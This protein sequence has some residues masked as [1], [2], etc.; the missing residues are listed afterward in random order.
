MALAT[1]VVIAGV[2]LT[3]W[4]LLD[5]LDPPPPLPE[6]PPDLGG[7]PV[8]EH[9]LRVAGDD[10]TATSAAVSREA[11][12]DEAAHAV[13]V[14]GDDYP[15]ALAGAALAG[16]RGGPVLL[17]SGDGLPPAVRAELAW[18]RPR[19]VT[20]LGGPQAVPAAVAEELESELGL[21]GVQRL[22]G[23]TRFETAARAARAATGGDGDR[24]YVVAADGWPD[25][26][27]VSALAAHQ[28]AP[29]LLVTR[30]GLPEPT[31]E[32]ISDLG[33]R[34]VT[35]VGG[36][37]AVSEQVAGRLGE[38]GAE[39]SRVAGANRYATSR[40]VA[41]L[42]AEAGLDAARPWLVTGGDWPDALV[43]G[44]AAAWV[45][46]PL[47]L[48]DGADLDRSPA[49]Q[50]WLLSSPRPRHTTVVGGQAV[51]GTSVVDDV[52]VLSSLTPGEGTRV[53]A[54][55]DIACDPRTRVRATS[56]EC[57]SAE[58]AELA[59]QADEVLVLGDLQSGRAT[60]S[61]LAAAY[62]RT[63]GA[64]TERTHP[65]I[66]RHEYVGG[67]PSDYFAYFGERA[68]PAGR[69]YYAR[70]IGGWQVLS[71][72]SNCRGLHDECDPGSAQMEWLRQ[73]LEGSTATCR[74]ALMHHARFSDGSTHG[75]HAELEA[76]FQ[77]L[78]DGGVDV[79]LAAHA[80]SYQRFRRADAAGNADPEGGVR[81]FVVGTGGTNL[82]P[83]DRRH[84]LSAARTDEHFGVLELTLHDA[85]YTWEFRAAN[86]HGVD[87][88]GHF[89][90]AGFGGCD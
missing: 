5:R 39:V 1:A 63:W 48:V 45:G 3:G 21:D 68:G 75:S 9:V 70:E 11:F 2:S 47:V 43:A 20:I 36:T 59:A 55:G 29:V 80:H 50:R 84:P 74:M 16:A 69:G 19:R 44:T 53:A 8:S 37:G 38:L 33:I 73:K 61:N 14:T 4:A 32:A 51:V 26:V 41:E 12:P 18:L 85:G 17:A 22:H 66:G 35:I 65:A 81:S 78:A 87:T 77:V 89:T 54:A 49:T 67:D 7:D 31:A 57:R 46:Q 23:A 28:G 13:I 58:T 30:D 42:S 83:F 60:L 82:R 25:A 52:T 6:Q 40:A 86:E 71:L 64:F 27:T 76:M 15:D 56:T 90:D 79:V 62:D 24:A 10:R 88:G 72:D 34:D